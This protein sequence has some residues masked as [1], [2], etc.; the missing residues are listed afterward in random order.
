MNPRARHTFLAA[1]IGFVV[2]AAAGSLATY[3]GVFADAG[4]PRESE[5]QRDFWNSHPKAEQAFED[6]N[7]KKAERFYAEVERLLPHDPT[8]RFQ[9][10]MALANLDRTDEALEE[11]RLAVEFGWA[12]TE[13]LSTDPAFVSLR[14][15]AL[16]DRLLDLA[17]RIADESTVVYVPKSLDPQTPPPLIVT[18]HGL[19]ENPHRHIQ[20]WTAIADALGLVVAAPRGLKRTGGRSDVHS[21]GWVSE[22]KRQGRAD[23]TPYR[24]RLDESIAL[25]KQRIGIDETRVI[26]AGYSQG[27]VVA[28]ALLVDTPKRFCGTV[29]Q[30]P[31]HLS[32]TVDE[33]K[34]AASEQKTRSYVIVHEFDRLRPAG[35]EIHQAMS[36]AGFDTRLELVPKTDH[37]L[38]LNNDALRLGAV[39]FVLGLDG[40]PP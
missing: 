37:E 17:K 11:L 8:S 4:A 12:D 39:R 22:S 9:R 5:W 13:R 10:A 20:S 27:G 32:R 16:F 21:F 6:E 14:R 24:N 36:R 28:L 3:L 19:G 18:F 30:A 15:H 40:S 25:A 38:P 33:W 7:W 23:L 31:A 34:Q 26:L 29:V 1:A 35:E 2:F